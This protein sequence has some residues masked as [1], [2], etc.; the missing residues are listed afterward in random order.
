M[1]HFVLAALTSILAL[2]QTTHPSPKP[3]M[4]ASR[5]AQVLPD[6]GVRATGLASFEGIEEPE[7]IFYPDKGR[8]RADDLQNITDMGGGVVRMTL[9]YHPD[10]WDG[11]RDL[12]TNKDRQRAEVKGLGP[13]QKLGQTFEYD[14]TWRSNP[15]F[16]GADRFCHIFQLKATEGDKGAPLVTLS[17]K[18][19]TGDGCLQYY[20]GQN[21]GFVVAREFKW[22]PGQW[23]QVRIRI[24]TSTGNDGEVTA[25]ID[26]DD[27][28][29]ARNLPIYRPDA[30]DYRP[31]WGLYRGVNKGM[32]LGEDWIEHKDVTARRLDEKN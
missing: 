4:G 26:G 6:G 2:I 24:R 9:R 21:K 13:H 16:R 15:T 11:D 29:G 10:W 14:T 30:E 3:I 8:F 20:S 18:Q 23:Q 5:P 31:K 19:G 22:T 1:I 7:I 12:E 17:I 27:F 25:S 28:Q 32:R